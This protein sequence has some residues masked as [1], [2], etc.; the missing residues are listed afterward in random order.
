[1]VY[2]L[3]PRTSLD[4]IVREQALRR[5]R[6]LVKSVAASM[7]LEDQGISGQEQNRQ[8]EALARN[9]LITPSTGFWDE[10]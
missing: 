1:L 6:T 10:E 3:V 5:A 4:E 8:V 9:L 7:Q 2:A